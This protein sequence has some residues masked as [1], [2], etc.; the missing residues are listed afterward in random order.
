MWAHNLPEH[1]QASLQEE[2]TL[3]DPDKIEDVIAQYIRSAGKKRKLDPAS[4][5]YLA[6]Q[7]AEASPAE[8]RRLEEQ[9]YGKEWA[10][11]NPAS[12]KIRAALDKQRREWY[13]QREREDIDYAMNELGRSREQAIE[14]SRQWARD[15]PHRGQAEVIRDLYGSERDLSDRDREGMI[16]MMLEEGRTMEEAMSFLAGEDMTWE[17]MTVSMIEKFLAEGG[18]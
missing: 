3:S 2:G 18:P 5:K 1:V 11:Q 4:E 12:D 7:M 17:D 16:D 9:M 15:N 10:K 8:S 14:D 13:V 6:A